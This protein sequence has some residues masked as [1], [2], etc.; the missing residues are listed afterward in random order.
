MANEFKLQQRQIQTQIQR[1]NQKQ[2]RSLK[3][4]SLGGND[5][6]NELSQALKENPA[7][8]LASNKK[9]K[10]PPDFTKIGT[11]GKAGNIA[12]DNYQKALESKQDNRKSLTENFIQQLNIANL[13]PR[14]HDLCEK[15]IMNLSDKGYHVLS[16]LSFI[17]AR[18]TPGMLD[19][20]ISIIQRMTPEG[21]C[22]K[23]MEESLYVQAKL[24]DTPPVEALFI[25]NGHFDFLNP[26]E[27]ERIIKKINDYLSKKN[28]LFG[29]SPDLYE[30]E[31]CLT[32]EKIQKALSFIR[33]LQPFPANEYGT[34]QTH[35]IAP[36]VYVKPIPEDSPEYS[37]LED[38]ENGIVLIAGKPYSVK[39]SRATAPELQLNQEYIDSSSNVDPENIRKAKELIQMINDRISTLQKAACLIVKKQGKFFIKGPGNLNAFTQKELSELMGLHESTIS[40]MANGKYIECE[41]GLFEI[42]TFFSTPVTKSDENGKSISK[43]RVF[44][45]INKILKANASSKKQLSDQKISDLLKEKGINVARRTVAKYRSQMNIQSS[46]D[47]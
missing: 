2:I 43:D 9:K 34:S 1:M 45:E 7:L 39:L 15:L 18:T 26:P 37:T 13:P 42:K 6:K 46:Y 3:F 25:L 12:S 5:F 11:S 40:R 19:K 8:T 14:E 20:C 38:F 30:E 28:A 44:A 33:T 4:L 22:T 10:G 32:P 27:P 36:D 47:R 29:A 35:Y 41:W 16:P 23:N 17:D 24:K 21:C 31:L